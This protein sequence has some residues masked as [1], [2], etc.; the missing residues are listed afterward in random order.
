MRR[1][2]WTLLALLTLT[3]TFVQ[4]QDAAI[5]DPTRTQSDEEHIKWIDHVMRSIATIQPG[6]TR[7]DL[8]RLFTTEGGLSS[9]T[10]KRY[11]YKHCP[12]IKVDV[13]FF[14]ADDLRGEQDP[15]ADNPADKIVKISKPFLEYSIMD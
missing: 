12:H 5:N 8:L 1:L 14:P 9:R 2:T 6:M 11:V 3:I 10:Q 15:M 7:K 13:E 4:A